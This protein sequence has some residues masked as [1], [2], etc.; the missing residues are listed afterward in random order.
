[1]EGM[2]RGR[3]GLGV[4]TRRIVGL[5]AE[6]GCGAAKASTGQP[7]ESH[8]G[9]IQRRDRA[10]GP[11]RPALG[12]L[13]VRDCPTPK[14][15]RLSIAEAAAHHAGGRTM[16][17]NGL[18]TP[19]STTASGG[20]TGEQHPERLAVTPNPTSAAYLER[21]AALVENLGD[22]RHYTEVADQLQRMRDE[23]TP[24]HDAANSRL[25]QDLYSLEIRLGQSA[26]H[27]RRNGCARTARCR[28]SML[29]HPAGTARS[30]VRALGV[31]HGS[32]L[33][34]HR[35]GAHRSLRRHRWCSLV[36][37]PLPKNWVG[38]IEPG[39]ASPAPPIAAPQAAPNSR[40]R[41]ADDHR[42]GDRSRRCAPSR[43]GRS[44]VASPLELGREGIDPHLIPAM[45]A[46][47]RRRN[48]RV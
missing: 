30:S 32:G 23:L 43:S 13:E 26:G 20:P 10:Q 39:R 1:M 24:Y 6:D 11:H 47:A 14:R 17:I 28:T 46:S 18:R 5:V 42:R 34:R 9:S 35:R 45:I 7:G 36:Q 21:E 29:F 38:S 22:F 44:D 31:V 33:A 15:P 8:V 12:E 41:D 48:S 27:A 25:L 19:L 16:T 4:S 2:L 40:D 3:N 37:K